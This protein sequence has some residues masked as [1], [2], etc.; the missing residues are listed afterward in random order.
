MEVVFDINGCSAPIIGVNLLNTINLYSNDGTIRS[1]NSENGLLEDLN[2]TNKNSLKFCLNCQI[3]G[4][5]FEIYGMGD[6][7]LFI[8]KNKQINE[9]KR[10]NLE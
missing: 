7:D 1:F 10:N 5:N 6:D 8:K 2:T 4:E 3:E 9:F